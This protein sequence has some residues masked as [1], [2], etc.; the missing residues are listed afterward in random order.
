MFVMF[1]VFVVV[2]VDVDVDVGMERKEKKKKSSA[3]H[4]SRRGLDIGSLVP[5]L[6]V[7]PSHGVMQDRT[8]LGL[9]RCWCRGGRRGGRT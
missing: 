3:R 5:R 6:W 8:G 2:F 1:V 7:F 4:S 9:G